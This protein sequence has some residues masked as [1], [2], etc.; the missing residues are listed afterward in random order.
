MLGPISITYISNDRAD[1]KERAAKVIEV[2]REATTR[3][4][5]QD[6]RVRRCQAFIDMRHSERRYNF[7]YNNPGK[8]LQ[9]VKRWVAGFFAQTQLDKA[10]TL[11][12]YRSTRKLEQAFNTAEAFGMA[13]KKNSPTTVAQLEAKLDELFENSD[14]KAVHRT[15]FGES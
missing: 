10:V 15:L 2:L 13:L 4:G 12:T 1:H 9:C 11:H 3:Y 6:P 14:V 7:F 5:S 8:E